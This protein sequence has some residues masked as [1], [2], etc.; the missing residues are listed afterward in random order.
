MDAISGLFSLLYALNLG[1]AETD[2]T[3]WIHAGTKNFTVCS[4]YKMLTSPN[5]VHTFP[6]NRI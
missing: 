3:F 5:V 4:I 6:E 1:Q 2:K